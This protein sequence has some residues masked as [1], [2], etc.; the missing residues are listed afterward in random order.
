MK[1]HTYEKAFVWVGALVLI[2]CAGALVY[3]S[4]GMGIHLP[5][6]VAEVDPNQIRNTPPFDQPG[7]REIGPG[8]YEVVMLGQIWS[9]LPGE[10]RVPAGSEVTF[11]ATSADVIHGL[12]IE[13]TRL[14]LMLIPGQVSRNTIRFPEPGE[15]IIICHEYCG[16]GHHT[17]AGK[18]IVE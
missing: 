18:V 9:F 12:F 13:R 14:N 11:T 15:H 3:A 6:R 1:V 5:G 7:V 4:L 17:M 16:I 8:R 10:I 2:A